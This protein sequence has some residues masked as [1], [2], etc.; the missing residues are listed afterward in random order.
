MWSGGS[1]VPRTLAL[2]GSPSLSGSDWDWVP[3]WEGLSWSAGRE[4]GRGSLSAWG[5]EGGRWGWPWW[6]GLTPVV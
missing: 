4:G 2:V 1:A 6:E 3:N 5:G